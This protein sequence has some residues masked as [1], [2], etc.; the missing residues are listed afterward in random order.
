MFCCSWLKPR[1]CISSFRWSISSAVKSPPLNTFFD[2]FLSFQRFWF[3]HF[4]SLRFHHVVKR[5]LKK[6][7]PLYSFA[8]KGNRTP[9]KK[10]KIFSSYTS[11]FALMSFFF[12]FE[13][14]RRDF[15]FFFIWNLGCCGRGH[16]A[17]RLILRT[18]L[19]HQLAAL[20]A[21]DVQCHHAVRLVRMHRRFS[22][23]EIHVLTLYQIPVGQRG[24]QTGMVDKNV[25]F[26][27]NH[28]NKSVASLVV[29]PLDTSC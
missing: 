24:W 25:L 6:R 5:D 13:K 22:L 11:V 29:K 3:T 27:T 18:R 20:D 23:F 10:E 21:S 15:I 9:K 1:F 17:G 14:E 8:Q 19:A 16:G 26:R 28:P 4:Q 7:A 2:L 12:L